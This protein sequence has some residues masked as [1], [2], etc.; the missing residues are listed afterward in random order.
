MKTTVGVRSDVGLVRE[1][2]E[3]SYLAE[4]PVFVVADG[5][6]G[7]VAGEVASQT[8]V[9]IIE[10]RLQGGAQENDRAL[11][12]MLRDANAAI[13]NR[14]ADDASLTGMGTTCTLVL[15]DG[16]QA[17]IAHVGDSRAYLF[18]DGGLT[19]LTEDH[20][21]VERMVKQGRLRPEE[22]QHHPQRSVIT[23]A[24]GV[25]ADVQV[26][27]Q[28]VEL[29]DGDR[30]L[31]CSDGLTSMAGTDAI[32]EVLAAEAEPQPAADRLVDLANRA[33]GE[34]NVTVVVVDVSAAADDGGAPAAEAAA[35]SAAATETGKGDT[36]ELEPVE[37]DEES[38]PRRRSRIPRVIATVLL[39]ALIGIGGYYGARFM[40][41]NSFFVGLNDDD[42]VTI[43][44]GIPEEFAGIT[45]KD[46][47]RVTKLSWD[48][49]PTQS[50][51]D[52][53]KNGIKA[54]SLEEAEQT[55]VDLQ[56]RTRE[57]SESQQKAG[58]APGGNKDAT[59]G[60]GSTGG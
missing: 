58:D 19:Q 39:L 46:E 1:G 17:H 3:D 43:Y 18:R 27:V 57:F 16:N 25:D 23:R 52:N 59:G 26:D 44:R 47:V 34:D 56:D 37:D 33:G 24:L 5:M 8:T 13:R 49:L 54:T 29:E 51:K 50:L 55:T 31:L 32:A 60:D 4:A 35:P 22:A 28:D 14:A 42:F 38:E 15:V 2:N 45:L 41:D 21:L 36:G 53:V 48:E 9:G 40:L 30:L 20:T 6:G 12:E 7:H 10:E 11:V